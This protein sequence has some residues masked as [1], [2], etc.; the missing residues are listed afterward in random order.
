MGRVA[1]AMDPHAMKA[2]NARA[3]FMQPVRRPLTSN[4]RRPF[5]ASR[6]RNHCRDVWSR[7]SSLSSETGRTTGPSSVELPYSSDSKRASVNGIPVNGAASDP[8]AQP[9]A[10]NGAAP[11]AQVSPLQAMHICTAWRRGFK[12]APAGIMFTVSRALD[13]GCYRGCIICA[14]VP[15]VPQSRHQFGR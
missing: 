9:L 8:V 15:D 3:P 6:P 12:S 2:M 5:T 14:V 10:S 11:D 7:S 13:P 1:M 4:H